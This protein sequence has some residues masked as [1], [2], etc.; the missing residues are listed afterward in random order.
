M[1]RIV[2]CLAAATAVAVCCPGAA[3]AASGWTAEP[4][5]GL[6]GEMTGV[7]CT[8][9]AGCIAVGNYYGTS[10]SYDPL[11]DRWNGSTWTVQP[12]PVPA[13]ADGVRLHGVS[14]HPAGSCTAVGFYYAPQTQDMPQV[15]AEH[16]N[17]STW[18]LQSVPPPPGAT[19]S[20]LSAV[21]CTSPASCTAAGWY[22]P[23][24]GGVAPLAEHWDGST[25]TIQPTPNPAGSTDNY[26]NAVSCASAASC[27]AVGQIGF[28]PSTPL[29]E[30]WDGSTWA[31]QAVAPSG[32]PLHGVS[33]ISAASCTAVGTTGSGTGLV[34]HW[35]GSAW[36][37]QPS[38][39]PAAWTSNV[40]YGV[41]CVPLGECTAAGVFSTQT[42][43]GAHAGAEYF[44][45]ST[46]AVQ[47]TAPPSLHKI[48]E[49][50]SCVAAR[51]CTAVGN[52]PTKHVIVPGFT[53]PLLAEGE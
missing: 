18:Q 24:S 49:A 31:I 21:S 34:E 42:S 37:I 1:K 48:L 27:T 40:L 32:G 10:G 38:P 26:L 2:A 23:G 44:N 43:P 17:G 20:E 15:L 41:S 8:A 19:E 35:D 46:W 25:W 16:W 12:V 33:C 14:C 9:A 51:D 28:F 22:A 7:S 52:S 50:V 11:A 29:A 5:G 45:G 36:A 47:H 30:H 6:V 3:S 53:G 13:G 39:A 4:T